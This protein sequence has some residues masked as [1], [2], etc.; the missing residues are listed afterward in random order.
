MENKKII[1][2]KKN[3][4][5]E[6]LYKLKDLP[7]K[8]GVF[9][10]CDNEKSYFPLSKILAHVIENGDFQSIA[11]LFS[12]FSHNDIRKAWTKVRPM[13]SEKNETGYAALIDFTD[14]FLD[15]KKK[16]EIQLK[17]VKK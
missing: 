4:E 1:K 12:E 11:G 13:F 16:V 3:K 17:K 6:V 8:K 7:V 15:A 10:F 2:T 5:G 14:I 9:W